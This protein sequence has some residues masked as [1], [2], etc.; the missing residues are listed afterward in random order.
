MRRNDREITEQNKMMEILSAC[1]C[2]RLGLIDENGAYIVPLNFGYEEVEGKIFLY[3]H[4]AAA[5][6]KFDLIRM[7][8]KASFELDRKHQLIEGETACTY[9][10]LYQSIMGNGKIQILNN[11]EEKIHAL[12]MLMSHYSDKKDWNFK[13]E[14][15][16]KIA[17]IKMEVTN[18]SCKE[19]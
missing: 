13:K 2:C 16:E 3:F 10:Y 8:K 14:Q 15:V 6:K 7:Q 11:Y 9:S 1:E 19:H 12:R 4:G 5:G 17:V 18:W